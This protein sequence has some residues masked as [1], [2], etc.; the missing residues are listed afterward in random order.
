MKNLK[1]LLVEMDMGGKKHKVTVIKVDEA[2]KMLTLEN[3]VTK[4]KFDMTFEA[5]EGF[6]GIEIDK[7]E[8]L[9]G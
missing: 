3:V 7:R 6:S 1:G 8:L 9:K 5:F 4:L 2:R